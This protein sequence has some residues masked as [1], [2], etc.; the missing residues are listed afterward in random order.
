MTCWPKPRIALLAKPT[1]AEE[2]AALL[3]AVPDKPQDVNVSELLEATTPCTLPVD[4]FAIS[5]VT[6]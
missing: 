3:M 5:Q 4:E 2:S 6:K 1:L